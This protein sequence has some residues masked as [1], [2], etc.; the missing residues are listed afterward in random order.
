MITSV[1]N[2]EDARNLNGLYG[3]PDTG[4]TPLAIHGRGIS[5][6]VIGL[7]FVGQGTRSFSFG[8][9]Y[10]VRARGDR[11]LDAD[12]VAENPGV[13]A[14]EPCTVTGCAPASA[15]RPVLA[16][17][18]GDAASERGDPGFRPGGRRDRHRIAGANLSCPLSV[19]FGGVA[20]TSLT[21]VKTILGCGSSQSL[22]ATAPPGT[23]GQTVPVTVETAESFYTGSA[24]QSAA[25]FSYR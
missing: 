10:R 1:V 24:P 8:T 7:E 16:L 11:V 5:G 19:Q 4:R 21:V 17:S 12:S 15:Q 20:A 18:A 13:V 3:G 25:S 6:Q 2:T 14:V 22:A 9:Q 23:A